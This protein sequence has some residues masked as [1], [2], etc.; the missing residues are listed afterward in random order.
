MNQEDRYSRQIRFAGIGAAGQ[1]R[2]RDSR[3]VVIGCG[4][5]GTVAAE[6]LARAGVGYLKLIDRDVV[7]WSNLQ[8]QS[9][10][11]ELDA[12]EARPKATAAAR[13]LRAINSQVHVE[14]AV[15]DLEGDNV[16]ALCGGAD[17]LL[18]GTDNF[19]TRYLLND[20]AV[21][22]GIPWVYGAAVGSYGLGL[23]VM[24][25]QTPCLR[26]V[27]PDL[28]A[29]GEGESC[30]TVGVIAPIIH[31]VTG[32]QVASVLRILVG[33][34]PPSGLF[35]MDVWR[36]HGRMMGLQGPN[37]DCPCCVRKEFSYLGG[38]FGSRSARLCGRNAVQ[39]RPPQPQAIDL[40]NLAHR[41]APVCRVRLGPEL[42]RFF[43]PGFEITL[44]PDGRA[45][46][47]GTEDPAEARSLYA[48]YIGA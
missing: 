36:D 10:F 38:S 12:E 45:I 1:L 24:P 4:A 39:V 48:R 27:F 33:E 22:Q 13:A 18:D 2:L 16:G 5:L 43:P 15:V 44:F 28:P 29:A 17:V 34:R 46:V 14:A 3:V 8:R 20:Y 30:E 9:L 25:G 31:M 21:Q 6:M 26:C 42:L 37:I 7:E 11:T 19:E 47:R 35:Q 41:L 40:E 32:F 23:A